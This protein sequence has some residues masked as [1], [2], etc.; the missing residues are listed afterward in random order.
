MRLRFGYHIIC[1]CLQRLKWSIVR[2]VRYRISIGRRCCQAIVKWSF[3]SCK[4]HI[5]QICYVEEVTSLEPGKI[6]A[7]R[8]I[9]GGYEIL[10]SP[11]PALLTVIDANDPRPMNVKLM[12]KYKRAR[13]PGEIDAAAKK[14]EISDAAQV[15]KD[16]KSRGLLIEEYSA[17]DIN[18]D[19]NRIGFPG[20]PTKVKQVM[21]VVLTAGEAK[22]VS[23]DAEGI[24]GLMH[25]LISD[26]T[27]G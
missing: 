26:H 1:K 22:T 18:A 17:A 27:L 4:L 12:M 14:G 23:A 15:K 24:A 11:T 21:S 13:T 6:V 16:L 9:E 5:P 8:A 20:S 7:R 25:E 3:T 2:S 10:S 19:P